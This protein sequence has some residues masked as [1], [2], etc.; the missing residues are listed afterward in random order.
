MQQQY[1]TQIYSTKAKHIKIANL[2]YQAKLS[3]SC[4]DR[5]SIKGAN[6]WHFAKPL[7]APIAC[8]NLAFKK[9]PTFEM[10]NMN[11]PD[12]NNLNSTF[13]HGLF[14]ESITI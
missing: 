7:D 10:S 5:T 9:T 2:Y 8:K 11:K 6:V 4:H 1:S 3:E 13:Q 12:I 14:C